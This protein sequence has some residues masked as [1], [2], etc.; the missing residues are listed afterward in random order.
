MPSDE[1]GEQ[2]DETDALGVQNGAQGIWFCAPR[3]KAAFTHKCAP[4][5]RLRISRPQ[6]LE[7]LVVQR[8]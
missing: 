5:A 3:M 1:K 8:R 6:F 7:P 4:K 2:T